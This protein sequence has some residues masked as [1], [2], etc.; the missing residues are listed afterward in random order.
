MQLIQHIC[1]VFSLNSSML[2][3]WRFHLEKIDN[4]LYRNNQYN[5][6]PAAQVSSTTDIF[7]LQE[8][9]SEEISDH[10]EFIWAGSYFITPR[11]GEG[12]EGLD[13]HQ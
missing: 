13:A 9:P 4:P 10:K 8:I 2:K 3:K 1:D 7:I 11:F 5:R 12:I 6:I